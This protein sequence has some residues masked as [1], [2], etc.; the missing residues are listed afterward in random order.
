LKKFG[1]EVVIEDFAFG[2]RPYWEDVK[3]DAEPIKALA[4]KY[5]QKRIPTAFTRS[6]ERR[7]D[8]LIEL[9]K[10]FK[11]DG[12]VYYT[13][14]YQ[15]AYQTQL[16]YLDRILREELDLPTLSLETDYDIMEIGPMETRIETFVEAMGGS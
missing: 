7:I 1:A 4:E 10:E 16:Y 6:S 11:I 15:D 8:G 13:P 5:L 2:I 9:A 14:M 3:A 12:I